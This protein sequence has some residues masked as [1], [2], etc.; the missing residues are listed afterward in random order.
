MSHEI[1][2]RRVLARPLPTNPAAKTVIQVARKG[3][4]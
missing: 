3:V 2:N 4:L 1:F